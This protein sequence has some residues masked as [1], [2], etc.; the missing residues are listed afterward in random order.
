MIEEG[1]EECRDAVKTE[2]NRL[3]KSRFMEEQ[4]KAR[5]TW[6]R[7]GYEMGFKDGSDEGFDLGRE[8]YQIRYPCASARE[9]L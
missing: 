9:A 6:R 1:G 8:E 2:A 7:R 5:S 3:Y 4:N